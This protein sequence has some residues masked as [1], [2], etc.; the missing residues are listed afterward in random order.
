M[1]VG[2]ILT[3]SSP[4]KDVRFNLI[5]TLLNNM[6]SSPAQLVKFN[7]ISALLNSGWEEIRHRGCK[8]ETSKSC[9]SACRQRTAQIPAQGIKLDVNSGCQQRAAQIPA[10]GIKLDVNSGHEH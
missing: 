1:P 3:V 4:A 8:L 5:C 9:L 7:L 6:V 10:Q 2:R